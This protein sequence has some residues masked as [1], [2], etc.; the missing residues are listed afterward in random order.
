MK[1]FFL[2][3][4]NWAT[5]QHDFDTFYMPCSLIYYALCQDLS[6]SSYKKYIYNYL[7]EWYIYVKQQPK[8]KY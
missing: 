2:N 3:S 8:F 7:Q 5:H 6:T 1:L 4:L